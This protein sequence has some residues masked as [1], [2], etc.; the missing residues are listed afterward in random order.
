MEPTNHCPSRFYRRA[1]LLGWCGLALFGLL[2]CEEPQVTKYE[3]EREK[4]SVDFTRL[5]GYQVPKGWTRLP[6]GRE[7]FSLAAFEVGGKDGK[8][9]KVTISRLGSGGGGLI[10]NIIRWREQ[11]GH[12]KIDVRDPAVVE[13]AKKEIEKE[14]LTLM[15]DGEKTPYVDLKNPDPKKTDADRTLGVIAERGPVTWFFKMQGPAPLVEEQKAAFEAFVQSVK[16]GGTGGND[17]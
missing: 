17:E 10:A 3:A 8:S 11:V 14:L 6:V 7:S 1:A 15:V 9:A 4:P 2:G 12:E 16:F 13:M 5:S